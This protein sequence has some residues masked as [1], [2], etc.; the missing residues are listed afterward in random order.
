MPPRPTQASSTATP[1]PGPEGSATKSTAEEEETVAADVT[2]TSLENS[3][4][5]RLEKLPTTEE[6]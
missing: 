6:R 2:A 1:P 3:E 4:T 5:S